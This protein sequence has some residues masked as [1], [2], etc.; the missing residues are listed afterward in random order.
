MSD[1]TIQTFCC[2]HGNATNVALTV[3]RTFDTDT[4]NIVCLCSSALGVLGAVY[5][6]LPRKQFTNSHRWFSFPAE[7]GRKII[8]WLA[9]A[10]LL[11]ALGV[12]IRSMIWITNKNIMPAINDDSSVFF[13][14][15]SSA[16][17]QYFYTST[18]IW[19]LCYAIDMRLILAQ[20]ECKLR[21]YHM[22]AWIIPALLTSSGLCLLYYPDADCHAI[23]SFETILFRFVPNYIAT[24]L[25]IF[26]VMIANPILYH[27]SM[28]DM[29]RIITSASGQ[30]TS[31]ER[32]I[33]DAISL[34][35][36]VIMGVFYL[37]WI[38]NL[39]NGLLVWVLWFELPSDVL[40]VVWNIMAFT[41]PLQ[42]FFNSLVYR[43]WYSGSERVILPWRYYDEAEY[44]PRNSLLT[45]SSKDSGRDEG[46]PLLPGGPLKSIN[47]YQSLP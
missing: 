30:L 16:L 44:T 39:V 21:Y 45:R 24:Y 13:C 2:H 8:I 15:I 41:N 7:R 1:P 3:M 40:I 43:R 5:Q 18:C 27:N 31:R 10:D 36:S 38:P 29:K 19:T 46:Y 12:F 33:L 9:V 22:A 4:Y 20:K 42:A 17:I 6:I 35:F 14:S 47:G 23:L 28:G 11:A 26:V 32:S 34:K 25:P 37:C